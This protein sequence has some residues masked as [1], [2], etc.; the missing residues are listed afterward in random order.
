MFKRIKIHNIYRISNIY[1]NKY[2]K[3]INRQIL[4]NINLTNG[5]KPHK[6]ISLINKKIINNHFGINSSR[7]EKKYVK[8]ITTNSQNLT[9]IQIINKV[10]PLPLKEIT[11]KPTSIFSLNI[12]ERTSRNHSKEQ[13]NKHHTM[14]KRNHLE[15]F[16][17]KNTHEIIYK[18]IKRI[19]NKKSAIIH[20]FLKNTASTAKMKGLKINKKI[21]NSNNNHKGVI[22]NKEVFN[23]TVKDKNF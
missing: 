8:H 22:N 23:K 14:I 12:T 2:N 20:S 4:K 13:I 19:H 10:S 16:S 17:P 9:G 21:N 11:K 3:S 5:H 7:I 18:K 1:Y 6:D 15:S